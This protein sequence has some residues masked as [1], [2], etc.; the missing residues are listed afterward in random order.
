MPEWEGGRRQGAGVVG[1]V[2][3]HQGGTGSGSRHHRRAIGERER[4][5]RCVVLK[6]KDLQQIRGEQRDILAQNYVVAC[7][8]FLSRAPVDLVA[9]VTRSTGIACGMRA[10][11]R[12]T[13]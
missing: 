5:R 7:V 4:D 9:I 6:E 3:V 1:V 13:S 10:A 12:H 8:L 11:W 2:I